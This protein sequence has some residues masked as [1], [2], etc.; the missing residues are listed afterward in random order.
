MIFVN[1]YAQCTSPNT[2]I[3]KTD[4][5]KPVQSRF[6][7]YSSPV[8]RMEILTVFAADANSDGRCISPMLICDD[9]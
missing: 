8:C 9:S 5:S 3:V 7:V 4:I 2:T 6:M 1:F